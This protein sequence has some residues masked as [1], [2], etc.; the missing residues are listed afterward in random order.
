MI[1]GHKISFKQFKHR[2]LKNAKDVKQL[3]GVL[4]S[5]ERLRSSGIEV[6]LSETEEKEN[7]SE[8]VS[9]S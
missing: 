4:E 9:G 7:D 6:N 2:L 5:F 3:E 8:P 1:V